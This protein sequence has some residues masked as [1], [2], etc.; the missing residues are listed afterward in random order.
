MEVFMKRLMLQKTGAI[1]P[2]CPSPSFI[3]LLWM[4]PN[5]FITF[6]E[7]HKTIIHR[8]GHP[9]QMTQEALP[10]LIGRWYY[11]PTDISQQQNRAIRIL[12]ML[13]GNRET[14][15]VWTELPE[16]LYTFNPNPKQEKIMSVLIGMLQFWLVRINQHAFTLRP[17]VSGNLRIVVTAGRPFRVI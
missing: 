6:T 3:R 1:F 11:L 2:I 15:Y 9:A 12:F 5:L 7:E 4:M 13:S 14:W 16:S 17:S 8:E 10:I